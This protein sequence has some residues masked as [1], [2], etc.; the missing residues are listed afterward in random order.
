MARGPWKDVG[1]EGWA[2][3][4]GLLVSFRAVLMNR[5]VE[6]ILKAKLTSE[7]AFRLTAN[8]PHRAKAGLLLLRFFFEASS[9]ELIHMVPIPGHSGWC[10]H[11]PDE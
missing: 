9:Q 11:R 10:P 1:G 2:C 8:S 4:G 5:L 7:S 3:W 6:V